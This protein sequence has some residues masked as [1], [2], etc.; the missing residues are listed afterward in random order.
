MALN[1]QHKLNI[2]DIA[3]GRLALS[4][5][6]LNQL[7]IFGPL[8]V[9]PMTVLRNRMASL[10]SPRGA[11]IGEEYMSL[12]CVF[13]LDP[14]IRIAR[15]GRM[16]FSEILD[17][18]GNNLASPPEPEVLQDPMMGQRPSARPLA[19]RLM[20]PA[21][22]G[23]RIVKAKGLIHYQ[24]YADDSLFEFHD[25][26][27]MVDEEFDLEGTQVRLQQFSVRGD[28]SV[29]MTVRLTGSGAVPVRPA[30]L[31]TPSNSL[32]RVSLVDG[33]DKVIYTAPVQ[34]VLTVH[35]PGPIL[36]PMKLRVTVPSVVR[37]LVIPFE[38]RDIPLP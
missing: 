35:I 8:A 34:T 15:L 24:V 6:G 3:Q 20:I 14:R 9:A 31:R 13:L 1:R 32:P 17:D 27:K 22:R 5:N 21:K 2:D 26:E 10:Q 7:F 33:A 36:A 37:D 12:S 38:L 19:V 30:L 4:E 25:A 11:E 23:S 18:L 29:D 28:K 16:Y